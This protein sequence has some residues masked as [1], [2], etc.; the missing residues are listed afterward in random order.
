V[1]EWTF[2]ALATMRAPELMEIL[3]RGVAPRFSALVG[4]EFRGWNV[5]APIGKPF[6]AALGIQRFAKGFFSR[7]VAPGG[8]VDALPFIEGY[9]VT[10]TNGRHHEPWVGAPSDEAPL[11]QS[12]F[13]AVPATGIRTKPD[14]HPAAVLIDYDLGDP[15]PPLFQGGALYGNGGLFDFVVH[16]SAAHTD[17]L[18]G[19]AYYRLPPLVVRGGVFV[20]ERWRQPGFAPPPRSR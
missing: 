18:V 19:V 20:A 1:A 12:Y 13:R 17:L 3:E 5:V 14:R 4:W 16:P 2:D 15:Q 9:N 7:D 6:A 11:R 8:D 10:I